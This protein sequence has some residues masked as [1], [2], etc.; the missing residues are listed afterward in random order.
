MVIA[1]PAPPVA[2]PLDNPIDPELPLE[3][4]PEVIVTFPLTREGAEAIPTSPLACDVE[5]PL[6]RVIAPP[7]VLLL[8]PDANEM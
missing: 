2:E 8:N 4:D 6:I 1:P 5:P 3:A 7:I